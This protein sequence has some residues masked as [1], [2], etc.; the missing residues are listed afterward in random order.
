MTQTALSAFRTNR[1]KEVCNQ[2]S[3]DLLIAS[4]AENIEYLS[5][6][7]PLG[8]ASLYST[9]AYLVFC[10]SSGQK[11]VITAAADAPTLLELGFSG[12]IY[13]VGGFCFTYIDGD[14]MSDS[15]RSVLKK[16]YASVSD[17]LEAA[18]CSMNQAQ[19]RIAIDESRM[20]VTTWRKLEHAFPACELLS[21]ASIFPE[22]RR[23]KHPEEI[24]LLKKSANITESSFLRLLPFIEEGVSEAELYW[25]FN[26]GII[27]EGATPYFCAITIDERSAFVDTYPQPFSK[28]KNGS[29]LRFD[30]GCIYKGF[31]SDIARMVIVGENKKAEAYYAGV[32]AGEEAAIQALRPGISAGEIFDIAVNTVKQHI[33]HFERHHCGHGIG[34][35]SYD[36]PSICAGNPALIEQ[37]M[38]LCIE[39][40]YYELGWGGVMVEDT[41]R[42]TKDGAEFLTDT[43]RELIHL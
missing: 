6:F 8:V 15:V 4:V 22:I 14:R 18:I 32:L 13:P 40:P 21:A 19:A 27:Q 34:M 38:T 3:V 35:A 36:F 28:V 30:F 39:T 26:E 1:A 7:F 31:R 20:P 5:G 12:D 29:V 2:H 37:D 17:A 41:V 11:A 42:I 10:P 24:A 33:P 23:I 25:H 9:E 43:S 16:R